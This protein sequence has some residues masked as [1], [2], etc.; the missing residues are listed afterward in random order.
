MIRSFIET[1]TNSWVSQETDKFPKKANKRYVGFASYSQQNGKDITIGP[2][3]P[4]RLHPKIQDKKLDLASF[5]FGVVIEGAKD[6]SAYQSRIQFEDII[7]PDC[8]FHNTIQLPDI[9]GK[10]FIGGPK[11][12]AGNWWYF[13]P[14]RVQRRVMP[15]LQTTLF[16]GNEYRGRKFYFH[17]FPDNALSWYDNENNWPQTIYRYPVQTIKPDT[18]INNCSIY[19]ERIPKALLDLFILALQPGVNIKHKIGYGKAF[20]LGS[21][22]IAIEKINYYSDADFFLNKNE[23]YN[24]QIVT[25]GGFKDKESLYNQYIDKMSLKWLARILSKEN[26]HSLTFT[27]PPFSRGFF[28][29]PVSWKSYK[30]VPS[31]LDDMQ[32]ADKLSNLKQTINFRYYQSKSNNWNL[33]FN[34]EP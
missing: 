10:P 31:G 23:E 19:F 12:V 3:I 32:I 1:L 25:T 5:L 16:L 21:I 28:Q 4:V 6:N 18:D 20:G 17:Q 26:M 2:A 27:Y 34:R 33:V 24:H 8:N 15:D 9:P 7:V 29:T 13:E 22:D 14:H 11:P 30:A